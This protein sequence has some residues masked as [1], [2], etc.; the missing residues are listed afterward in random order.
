MQWRILYLSDNQ[1]FYRFQNLDVRDK[2]PFCS[3]LM[4][5][6]SW[7]FRESKISYHFIEI[8]VVSALTNTSINTQIHTPVR[9]YDL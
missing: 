5:F 7:L 2:F 1:I 6:I 8:L 4:Q 3:R 9:E